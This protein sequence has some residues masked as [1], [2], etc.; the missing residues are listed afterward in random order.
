MAKK[1][2]KFPITSSITVRADQ[3]LSIDPV[4][5]IEEDVPTPPFFLI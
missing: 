4:Q 1:W 2:L 5:I 3:V